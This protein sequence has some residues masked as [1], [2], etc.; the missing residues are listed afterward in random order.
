MCVC[1]K[2]KHQLMELLI[3]EVWTHK[4]FCLVYFDLLPLNMIY[5]SIKSFD[6]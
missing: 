5:V 6:P 3:V 4:F 1:K 2:L